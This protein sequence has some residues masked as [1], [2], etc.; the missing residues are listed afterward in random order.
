MDK[1][2]VPE[3]LELINSE[4]DAKTLNSDVIKQAVR[5]LRAKQASYKDANDFAIEV[6][7]ILAEVFKDNISA[8]ILPDGRMYY[9][10]AE[11]IINETLG[12][13]HELIAGYSEDVQA[14]MN[15]QAQ[16]GIKAQ[17]ADLN[18]SRIDGMVERL[19]KEEDYNKIKW[20]MDEPVKNFS[21]SIV[22]DSIRKNVEFH[23][24]SGLEPKIVRRSTGKCCD[25][26]DKLTGTYDYETVRAIGSD[27]F[28]RHRFCRCTVEYYPGDGKRQNVH[29]KRFI[30][31]EK[32]AKIEARKLIAKDSDP[33]RF[34]RVNIDLRQFSEKD[35]KKQN[36]AAIEKG[37]RNLE[38]RI[39]EHK[40]KIQHPE[41][42][43]ADW[44]EVS[45]EIRYGRINYWKKE[46]YNF[47]KSIVD[48]K[49]YLRG[50]NND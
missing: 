46:I 25:W 48:R 32:D 7:D 42:Y 21:Q 47:E 31:S 44:Y 16:I 6:G 35:L 26:C 17:K 1:D 12:K 9:N 2:I 50:E 43:Y 39:E 24:K 49:K 3:L 30:D 38:K 20:M 28:R 34:K 33:K 29:T 8:E 14:L 15:E 19:A 22:D 13:N 40:Q 23:Y 11:R 5:K 36:A 37:I 45:P 4:F 18:Q 41:R 10:I 27:V